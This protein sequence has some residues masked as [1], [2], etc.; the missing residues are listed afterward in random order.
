MPFLCFACNTVSS[1]E[2]TVFCLFCQCIDQNLL[3]SRCSAIGSWMKKTSNRTWLLTPV[4]LILQS[5]SLQTR[6]MCN[7]I[8]CSIGTNGSVI[9]PQWALN[10]PLFFLSYLNLWYFGL[11]KRN[12]HHTL[13]WHVL[14][15]NISGIGTMISPET[16]LLYHENQD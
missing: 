3:Q 15:W 11:L 9:H 1:L 5:E 4:S 8:R 14:S 7:N 12:G 10:P 6:N 16:Q 2:L 13:W